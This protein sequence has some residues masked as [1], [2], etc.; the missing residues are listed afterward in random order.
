MF[1]R[2]LCTDDGISVRIINEQ[3][4]TFEHSFDKYVFMWEFRDHV[5]RRQLWNSKKFDNHSPHSCDRYTEIGRIALDTCPIRTSG[6]NHRSPVDP[7]IPATA[8]VSAR[9]TLIWTRTLHVNICSRFFRRF[10]GPIWLPYSR[11]LTVR[12]K[13]NIII[14]R[15]KFYVV[16]NAK[17]RC[18]N[19]LTGN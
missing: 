5:Q 12:L 3:L 18:E 10:R 15:L 8:T 2:E 1:K 7:C 17:V 9:K 4:I 11:S 13:S 6:P 19:L 14:C 16:T